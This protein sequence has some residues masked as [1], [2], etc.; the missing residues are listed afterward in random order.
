MCERRGRAGKRTAVRVQ[1]APFC[2]TSS[3][4]KVGMSLWASERPRATERAA[5]RTTT[6]WVGGDGGL[7]LSAL[8][9]LSQSSNVNV[10]HTHHDADGR[11]V[12]RAQDKTVPNLRIEDIIMKECGRIARIDQSY[13]RK[14]ARRVVGHQVVP[15]NSGDRRQ[16]SW[17]FGGESKGGNVFGSDSW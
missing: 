14:N 12:F 2:D 7:L 4:V 8:G 3:R 6:A 10:R 5:T 15:C 11:F 17:D 9:R 1:R 16:S 13:W